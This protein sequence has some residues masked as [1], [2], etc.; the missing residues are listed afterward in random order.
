MSYY[1]GRAIGSYDV[2]VVSGDTGATE[3]VTSD[4]AKNWLRL[5]WQDADEPEELAR[6]NSLIITAR[7]RAERYLQRDVVSKSREIFWTYLDMEDVNIPYPP[8]NVTSVTIDGVT[9]VVDEDY[10]LLGFNN[11][12]FRLMNGPAERVQVAYT[13]P[14]FINDE[15]KTGIL[16][17][18]EEMYH[19]V[20]T[21]WKM[22][23]SPFKTAGYYGQR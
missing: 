7:R 10:E 9:G 15:V 21:Q 6:I 3:P 5:D 22:V 16:M 19:D 12:F 4:E 2:R 11:P 13:T 1:Y 8:N 20:K 18:V 23:L 17:L 14:N